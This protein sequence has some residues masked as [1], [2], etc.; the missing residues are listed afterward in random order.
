[1]AVEE[2]QEISKEK[3]KPTEI[4]RKPERIIHGECSIKRL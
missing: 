2:S 4:K 3:R 1:M